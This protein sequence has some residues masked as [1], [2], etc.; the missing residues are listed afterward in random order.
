ML[1]WGK[2]AYSI[3]FFFALRMYLYL[4]SNNT[5]A[6][7]SMLPFNAMLEFI[8]CKSVSSNNRNDFAIS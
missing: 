7:N 1:L 5:V 3:M 6:V 2:K 4:V 8:S